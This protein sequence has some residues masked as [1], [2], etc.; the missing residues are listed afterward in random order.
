MLSDAEIRRTLATYGAL[1]E[2]EPL[3]KHTSMH[4]GGSAR[5]FLRVSQREQLPELCRWLTQ[6]QIPWMGLGGGSNTVFSD[7]GFAGVVLCP[8][9]SSVDISPDG[10]VIAEAGS[11]TA[12]FAR[13]CT[14]AG[15]AGWEWGVGLPGTIGGAIVGNAGCFEG[16][17]RDRLVWVEAWSVDE[18]MIVRFTADQCQFGY[19]DS[20]FKHG[21]YFVTRAAWQLSPQTDREAS[22]LRMQDILQKRKEEQPLGSSS[23]GCLFKNVFVNEVELARIESL[24]GKVPRSSSETMIVPAGWLIEQCGLKGFA[25]GGM[26]VS[27]RHANFAIQSPSATST[28]LHALRDEIRR[29]VS[30]K[31]G[32]ILETEVRIV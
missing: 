28:D 15:W 24:F 21:S 7:E 4:L 14:E 11:M 10:H 19:R 12:L 25:C 1:L 26:R 8:G 27:D 16:E 13:K 30:E 32:V 29:V 9:F 22:I 31:G 6:Y 3:S 2:N 18:R 20:R 5:W 23:A 17:T